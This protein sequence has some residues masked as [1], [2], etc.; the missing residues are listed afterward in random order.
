MTT[1]TG[2]ATPPKD[3]AN[4]GTNAADDKNKPGE[5]T[6]GD[7]GAGGGG[8][9]DDKGGQDTKS[10]EH[11]K[12]LKDENVQRRQENKELKEKLARMEKGLA[13]LQGKEKPDLDPVEEAK[14]AADAKMRRLVLK[15]EVS[16]LASDAHDPASLTTAFAS[17]FKDVEFDADSESVDSEQV[18]A[19]VEG[20]R[21][22]KP[23]LFRTGSN[24]GGGGK[25]VK[26]GGTLPPDVANG[27]QGTNNGSMVAQWNQLKA[28]GRHE[29]AQA[30]Y[31]KNRPAIIAGK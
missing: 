8:A 29:E 12:K 11:I 26:L 17:A 3:E 6:G 2:G 23:Y 1:P 19:A 18:K 15:A 22:T 31:A 27:G 24:G 16:A 25:E 7:D 28:Q 5:G 20:L 4:K 13:I 10:A 14:K 9:G 30:F 21:K